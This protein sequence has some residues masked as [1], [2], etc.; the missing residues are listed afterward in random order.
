MLKKILFIVAAG[1]FAGNVSAQQA[2]FGLTAGYLNLNVKSKYDNVSAAANGSGFYVGGLAD[3]TLSE[4]LH[5]Q[6]EIL[7]GNAEDSEILYVPIMAKY[8]ISESNFNVQAGPELSFILDD[9]PEMK[10]NPLDWT[11]PLVLVMI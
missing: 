4:A 8:Y 7:Y 1:L 6:P 9:L 5:L 10:L 11:W 3:I 2:E